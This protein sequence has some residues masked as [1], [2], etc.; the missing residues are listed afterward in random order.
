VA[1]IP[2]PTPRSTTAG[3]HQRER[4]KKTISRILNPFFTKMPPARD[5]S[6]RQALRLLLFSD[7][8]RQQKKKSY[9]LKA[10]ACLRPYFKQ[11]ADV[12]HNES[13][14]S[15]YQFFRSHAMR[16]AT[17]YTQGL[18]DKGFHST[19]RRQQ[20]GRRNL[21]GASGIFASSSF[22]HAHQNE[23]WPEHDSC[24]AGRKAS[25]NVVNP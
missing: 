22:S 4:R 2:A 25:R 1:S 21:R 17:L 14:D 8:G 7:L 6:L 11:P 23:E 15:D 19:T 20:L 3:Q 18:D 10:N 5:F 24:K 13:L 12:H 9:V 16:L